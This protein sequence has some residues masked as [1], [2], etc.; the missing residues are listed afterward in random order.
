MSIP[1]TGPPQPADLNQGD[2]EPIH[3]PGSIQPHGLPLALDEQR[4]VRPGSKILIVDDNPQTAD[5]L[6]GLL[7]LSGFDVQSVHDGREALDA[8]RSLRPE[9]VLLDIGL[10]GMDGYE[11]AE[12]LR[13]EQG[14]E[15]AKL[16]AITGYGEEQAIRRSREAGFD[17]HLVKPVDYETLLELLISQAP[18][19]SA[20]AK[21]HA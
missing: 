15:D 12:R 5:A 4:L 8:A 18:P 14:L 11:V 6:A 19:A 13:R 17:H 1:S 7:E 16:I 3:R 21:G 20:S 10:P 9:A 2:R